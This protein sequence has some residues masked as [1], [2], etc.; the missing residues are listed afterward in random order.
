MQN[1]LGF[2]PKLGLGT[3]MSLM[4]LCLSA[5]TVNVTAPKNVTI[6]NSPAINSL[7]NQATAQTG[8]QPNSTPPSSTSTMTPSEA[9][10]LAASKRTGEGAPSGPTPDPN[11]APHAPIPTTADGKVPEF[12]ANMGKSPA[13][14]ST[15]SIY[16]SPSPSPSPSP[17]GSRLSPDEEAKALAKAG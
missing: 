15:P 2:Q 9:A 13:A 6:P 4:V 7:L 11:N 12:L 3:V 14:T 1:F 17:S 16:A 8:S 5:C 10:A